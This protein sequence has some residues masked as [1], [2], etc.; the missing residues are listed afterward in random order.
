MSGIL[1]TLSF[2]IMAPNSIEPAVSKL[3]GI[4]K[5]REYFLFRTEMI[6]IASFVAT[7]MVELIQITILVL[8]FA[9]LD[10]VTT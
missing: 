8:F 5:N 6:E 3:N 9:A 2:I 4:L 1:E 10:S 7:K